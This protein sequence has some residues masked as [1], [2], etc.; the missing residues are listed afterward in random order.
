MNGYPRRGN[1][2]YGTVGYFEHE[3]EKH[4]TTLTYGNGP[5]YVRDRPDAAQQNTCKYFKIRIL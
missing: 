2:I 5:G 1:D 3:T 4:F